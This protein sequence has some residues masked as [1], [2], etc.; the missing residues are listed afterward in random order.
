MTFSPQVTN[1]VVIKGSP[2]SRQSTPVFKGGNMVN[3]EIAEPRPDEKSE[4]ALLDLIDQYKDITNQLLKMIPPS[5]TKVLVFPKVTLQPKRQREVLDQILST[6]DG[7]TPVIEHPSGP[8]IQVPFPQ[9]LSKTQGKGSPKISC[10]CIQ[11][12]AA[13]KY[14]KPKKILR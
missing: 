14:K 13:S 2:G 12:P 11:E 8:V 3:V 4:D 9:F 6:L 1:N 10:K 5:S 7:E